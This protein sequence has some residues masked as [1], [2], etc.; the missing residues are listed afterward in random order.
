MNNLLVDLSYLATVGVPP[1]NLDTSQR[2]SQ[3]VD[4]I[5][6]V[7]FNQHGSQLKDVHINVFDTQLV[8][9]NDILNHQ[10]EPEIN[11]SRGILTDDS[12]DI[13][14]LND[15]LINP[16]IANRESTLKKLKTS[17]ELILIQYFTE[18]EN[19]YNL[20]EECRH[21]R[22]LL[23]DMGDLAELEFIN[24]LPQNINNEI[25]ITLS[26]LLGEQ[27]YA[28]INIRN[29]DI[30]ILSTD[31]TFKLN[32]VLV[33]KY[34]NNVYLFVVRRIKNIKSTIQL[35]PMNW[36][37]PIHTQIYRHFNP[38]IYDVSEVKQVE[39]NLKKNGLITT[40]REMVTNYYEELS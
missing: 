8:N 35:K 14:S 22:R 38:E 17:H 7:F 27:K 26:S 40:I 39:E 32:D 1:K 24:F 9:M 19:V 34:N 20:T 31:N 3:V 21:M 30:T 29:N 4:K 16:N 36:N 18:R 28:Q 11:H 25:Q 15:T 10:C 33:G 23:Y 13:R 37:I 5:L 2:A 12:F 6:S